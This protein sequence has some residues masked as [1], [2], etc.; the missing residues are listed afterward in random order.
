MNESLMIPIDW[1]QPLETIKGGSARLMGTL[2]NSRFPFV[3]AGIFPASKADHFDGR[4][5]D[6]SSPFEVLFSCDR[7][8]RME[9]VGA[10]SGRPLL[11]GIRNIGEDDARS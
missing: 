5:V 8:G 1:E 6:P 4:L 10:L 7:Y 2:K 9:P 3:V 11:R